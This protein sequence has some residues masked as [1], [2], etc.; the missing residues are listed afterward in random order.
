VIIRDV[1]HD[2]QMLFAVIHGM[3][4]PINRAEEK[5][6]KSKLRD[7]TSSC[8]IRIDKEGKWYFEGKEIINPLVLRAFCEALETDEDGRH[9]IVIRDELCYIDVEDTP[10]VISAIRGDQAA[11]LYLRLNTLET[12][13]LDPTRLCIGQDNV[14][15]AMLETGMKVRFTRSAYYSLAFMMEEDLSGNIV[16]KIRN[17]IYPICP[18]E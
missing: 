10:F 16:L 6:M 18:A 3:K 12:F 2:E 11:G 7:V 4:I 14:L 15:Y 17:T 5:P 9:R 13:P 8:R 1:K